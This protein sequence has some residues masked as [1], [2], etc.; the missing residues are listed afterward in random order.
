MGDPGLPGR[1]QVARLGHEV[2]Y[3][4]DAVATHVRRWRPNAGAVRRRI[5]LDVRRHSYKNHYL[6]IVKNEQVG[7]WLRDAPVSVA[8]EVARFGFA[9]LRDPRVLTAY[10]DALRLV[11]RALRHRRVIVGR[12]Q[13]RASVAVSTG[14][15]TV[16]PVTAA[17]AVTAATTELP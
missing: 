11:P 15:T 10:A 7:R 5:P 13:P 2:L 16:R 17:A 8:F 3:V 1:C 9:L 6:Q 12:A 14:R 4:H